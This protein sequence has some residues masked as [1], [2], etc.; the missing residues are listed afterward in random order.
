MILPI[1]EKRQ[2]EEVDS[3]GEFQFFDTTEN[4]SNPLG[5]PIDLKRS[6]PLF[7]STIWMWTS[8]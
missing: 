4:S 7:D 6:D 1:P 5:I 8:D 3:M 2:E